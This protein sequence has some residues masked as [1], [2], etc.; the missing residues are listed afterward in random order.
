MNPSRAILC[1]HKD[2][3]ITRRI[4]PS[5]VQELSLGQRT[6]L[7]FAYLTAL[8]DLC[9]VI[10]LG[11][12]PVE[13]RCYTHRPRHQ[14]C[15]TDVTTPL[16]TSPFVS[17]AAST[18]QSHRTRVLHGENP[19]E[20]IMPQLPATPT[21]FQQVLV[22]KA[23]HKKQR[24]SMKPTDEAP[25]PSSTADVSLT[26]PKNSGRSRSKARSTSR[27]KARTKS[28]SRSRSQS[29]SPSIQAKRPSIPAPQASPSPYKKA[30]LGKPATT[31]AAMERHQA[32]A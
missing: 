3:I 31:A 27:S 22:Q 25:S 5:E 12:E 26:P 13:L 16:R 17:S 21:A 6:Y 9:K 11:L 7:V 29:T 8:D 10:V 14:V 19:V 1:R 4:R 28:K 23:I 2:P 15:K 20:G 32:Q 30:L 24:Q 18:I